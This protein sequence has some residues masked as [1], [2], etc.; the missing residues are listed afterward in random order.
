MS[1][2]ANDERDA[3]RMGL[4]KLVKR[5]QELAGVIGGLAF[6]LA[7]KVLFGLGAAPRALEAFSH[8]QPFQFG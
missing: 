6:N 3:D 4:G 5:G 8:S 1:G 7:S 2:A